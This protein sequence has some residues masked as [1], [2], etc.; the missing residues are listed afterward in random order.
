MLFRPELLTN[1][2]SGSLQLSQ[3]GLG[4]SIVRLMLT[5]IQDM[6]STSANHM[7]ET[8]FESCVPL[9]EFLEM[10]SDAD[11]GMFWLPCRSCIAHDWSDAYQVI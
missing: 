4:Q 1:P 6:S 2:S 7:L 5:T 3:L 9:V 11:A 8:A 10:I